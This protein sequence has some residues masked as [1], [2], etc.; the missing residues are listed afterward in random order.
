MATRTVRPRDYRAD[1][2]FAVAGCAVLAWYNNIAGRTSWHRR[3]YPAVNACAAAAALAAAAAGGLG[4]DELGLRRGRM[5]AGLR[6]GAAAGAVI[7]AAFA[8]APVTPA[9]RLLHDKRVA[10]L[11]GRQLAYQVLLR[12]PVGTVC[13]EEAAFRGVLHAALCRVLPRPAAIAVGS[14]VFGVWHIRPTA[15]ALSGNQLAT[16]RKARIAAVA[17]VVAGTSAAGALLCCLRDRSGSL[18]A[19]VLAH[20]TANCAGPLTSALNSRLERRR[21]VPAQARTGQGPGQ[22]PWQRAAG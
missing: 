18:A 7:A 16:G 8:L 14:A 11:T 15:E 1:I 21:P 17:A 5:R 9:R 4:A 2:G 22:G 20:L 6:L 13:W 19:P 3:W 10:G 12:I